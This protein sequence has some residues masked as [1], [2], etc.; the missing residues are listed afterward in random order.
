MRKIALILL[1]SLI[2]SCSSSKDDLS[3]D[4]SEQD[5]ELILDEADSFKNGV[6]KVVSNNTTFYINDEGNKTILT[7]EQKKLQNNHILNFKTTYIKSGHTLKMGSYD[8]FSFENSEKGLEFIVYKNTLNNK[9]YMYMNTGILLFPNKK[10]CI[11]YI[12]DNLVD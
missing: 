5:A 8:Q 12:S 11:K 1:T 7:N 9:Y 6:A 2:F 4:N 3:L 10:T